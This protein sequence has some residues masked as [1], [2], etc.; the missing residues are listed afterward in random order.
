MSR[1]AILISGRGSNMLA[2]AEA[3][4]LGELDASVELVIS[5]RPQAPGLAAA[6]DLGLA[7]AMI[8]HTDFASRQDFDNALHQCLIQANPD[9]I[10]LAGFMRILTAE[11]VARWEGRIL[12]I[13]PSLLPLYP[14]LDTHA[15]AIA[16][17]DAYAGASVH[18]VS[19]ELDAGPVIAQVRIPVLPDDTADSLAGRLLAQEHDLYVRALRLCIQRDRNSLDNSPW[20]A[21]ADSKTGSSS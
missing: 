18:V 19:T 20:P 5:N 16:A 17:G 15:R 10:V 3:C 21:P 6:R 9:W 7:T 13:H 12:N 14:G 4:R 8:D 2:I 1:L 11:F